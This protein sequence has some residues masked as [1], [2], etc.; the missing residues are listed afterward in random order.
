MGVGRAGQCRAGALLLTVE[1]GVKG[2]VQMFVV[3]SNMRQHNNTANKQSTNQTMIMRSQSV[4]KEPSHFNE[5]ELSYHNRIKCD[6]YI[7][8]HPLLIT[9][10]YGCGSNTQA[11]HEAILGVLGYSHVSLD[12]SQRCLLFLTSFLYT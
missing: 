5:K 10:F 2:G 3:I 12:L 4:G 9:W 7:I 1:E 8:L 11:S 6:I